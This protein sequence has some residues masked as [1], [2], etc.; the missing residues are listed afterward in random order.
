MEIKE[1]DLNL[2]E[3][4]IIELIHKEKENEVET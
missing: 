3:S 4:V 2:Y 1:K